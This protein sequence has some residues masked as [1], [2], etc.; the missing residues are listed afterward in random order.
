M[1]SRLSLTFLGSQVTALAAQTAD[2][3]G[4]ASTR[5]TGLSTCDAGSSG[6]RRR[7]YRRRGHGRRGGGGGGGAGANSINTVVRT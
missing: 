7:G 3:S 1:I 2:C 4:G 6:Y 5:P